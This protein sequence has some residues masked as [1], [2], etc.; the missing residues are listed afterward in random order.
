MSTIHLLEL[1]LGAAV[2]YAAYKHVTY[3]QLKSAVK[4]AA[5]KVDATVVS[6]KTDLKKYL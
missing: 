2:V 4:T 5:S 1:G 3:A 6:I